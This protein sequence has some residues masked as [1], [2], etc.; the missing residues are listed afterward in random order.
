MCNSNIKKKVLP[1]KGLLCVVYH[2]VCVTV[3]L[4]KEGEK[5]REK[6]EEEA[7]FTTERFTLHFFQMHAQVLYSVF[8]F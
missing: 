4:K 7:G 6:K 8:V 3:T 1:L 2:T 5:R